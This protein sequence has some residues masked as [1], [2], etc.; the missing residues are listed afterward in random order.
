[1]VF[2]NLFK[3][4][5]EAQVLARDLFQAWVMDDLERAY[6]NEIRE[7]RNNDK[8]DESKCKYILF[9]YL[10]SVVAVALTYASEKGHEFVTVVRHFREH[11]LS[12]VSKVWNVPEEIFD[13][14][15]EEASNN[16]A[17]LFFTDPSENRAL[18]FEWSREWLATFGVREHNPMRL[19]KTAFRWKNS[20]IHLCD[21][22]NKFR[23]I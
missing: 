18:S 10:V 6:Q 4:K 13:Q 5:V 16:L 1:M 12:A 7:W 14:A 3:T 17:Q 20:Y 21:L 23:V 22:L 9:T 2:A 19:Y 8:F 15:V 11:A